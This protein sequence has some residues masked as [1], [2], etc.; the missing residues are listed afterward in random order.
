MER[1][2][3]GSKSVKFDCDL[4]NELAGKNELYFKSYLV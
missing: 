4:I 3:V 1:L 2:H